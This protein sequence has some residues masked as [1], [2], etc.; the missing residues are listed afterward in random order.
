M[1]P[2]ENS[3][4]STPQAQFSQTDLPELLPQYYKRLFPYKEFYSWLSYG[5]GKL[6]IIFTAFLERR[7]MHHEGLNV[8]NE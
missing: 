2:A 4:V 8:S 6:F 3:A 1:A 7:V 5:I